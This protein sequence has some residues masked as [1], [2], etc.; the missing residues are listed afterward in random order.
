MATKD[1]LHQI[2]T[3]DRRVAAWQKRAATFEQARDSGSLPEAE[4]AQLAARLERQR[5]KLLAALESQRR[6]RE[7]LA[8]TKTHGGDNTRRRLLELRYEIGED[9]AAGR[10]S[11][12]DYD[13]CKQRI[14]D[15]LRQLDEP[16]QP[17]E[18]IR[19]IGIPRKQIDTQKLAM[20]YWLQ[21][22][23]Q[24]R[25]RKGLPPPTEE[26]QRREEIL[27]MQTQTMVKQNQQQEDATTAKKQEAAYQRLR[28]SK[29]RQLRQPTWD[30]LLDQGLRELPADGRI[31]QLVARYGILDAPELL[32]STVIQLDDDLDYIIDSQTIRELAD[33]SKTTT[34]VRLSDR[35]RIS[36]AREII[37]RAIA[38]GSVFDQLDV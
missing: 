3:T 34:L 11:Q 30:W 35:V 37:K 25:E 28:R 20:V 15:S 4:L 32:R 17:G 6:L 2:Q 38:E 7:E 27:W 31:G 18:T 8:Q 1:E 22:R 33:S 24:V 19:V 36:V 12:D 26:E 5:D 23:R 29:P 21:A 13:G 16:P 10:I 14:E 9:L